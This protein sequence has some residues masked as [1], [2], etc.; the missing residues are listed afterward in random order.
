MNKQELTKKLA[1]T[2]EQVSS[3][4]QK[5]KNQG[6]DQVEIY[7]GFYHGNE[8]SLEK[9]D[10]NTSVTS[11]EINFGIRVIADHCQGFVTTN[12]PHSLEQ[13]IQEAKTLALAQHTPDEAM[14]LPP[15]VENAPQPI[16]GLYLEEIDSI[17][18]EDVVQSAGKIL[19]WRNENFPLI[20]L[21]SG[22]VSLNK[23]F[24]L[25]ANSHGILRSEMAASLSASFMGMAIDGDDISSFDY[26]G[27]T[28]RSK[29]LFLKD[30]DHSLEHFGEKCMGGLGAKPVKGFQGD[31]IIP[32]WSV[33][34]FLADLLSSLT[35]SQIRR[36]RSKFADKLGQQIVSPLLSIFEDPSIP[37]FAGSSSFDREGVATEPK[38][39][40][41][42]GV[43]K[44]F[45]YNHYEAK[46]AGLASSHGNAA[47]GYGSTPSCGPKQLQ[48]I[49]G[50]SHIKDMLY[51]D[52][53]T[54]FVNRFS[55]TSNAASGDF[56]GN[57]KGGAILHKG[58]RIPVK[59]L[60]ISGN[61]Y[62]ALQQIA[63]VS[64]E[65]ILLGSSS[66]VPWIKIEG[67]DIIG[68][69]EAN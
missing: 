44:H 54:V 46:K 21:D 42:A 11:E 56:S 5:A 49:P 26:D 32:P 43:L 62:Q 47:G 67:L 61:V 31:I 9:N 64:R 20:N 48:V 52:K 18:V 59:E 57:V 63:E 6:V 16:T 13:A 22:E 24:K 68:M 30:L 60:T 7:A 15:A 19:N 27:A 65:R 12:E 10:I 1:S 58:E 8:V 53:K 69:N 55:G 2:E 40:I 38:E 66:H 14:E 39:I 50:K 29:E 25:V 45:F 17:T 37:C 41:T 35:G 36:G 3:L 28:G 23:S 51:C 34:S 33:F 4:I